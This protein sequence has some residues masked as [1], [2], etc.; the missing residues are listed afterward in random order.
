MKTTLTAAASS[1]RGSARVSGRV[2]HE[3][4]ITVYCSS[5]ELLALQR[6]R[7][8]LHA[9]HN[10]RVDRGRLVREAIALALADLA[11][12]GGASPLVQ[13]LTED[14]PGAAQRAGGV[15]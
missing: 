6:A 1:E 5:G 11:E 4:K 7:L 14:T 2:T 3:E 10:I 15:R 8:A 12:R 13:R 9:D